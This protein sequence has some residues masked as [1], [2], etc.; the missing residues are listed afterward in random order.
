MAVNF[1]NPAFI[2]RTQKYRE[3]GLIVDFFC[4]NYGKV[5]AVAKKALSFKG[6]LSLYQPFMPLSISWQGQSELKQLISIESSGNSV[7]LKGLIFYS[8]CYLNELLLKLLP[9]AENSIELFGQYL[10]TINTLGQNP[11]RSEEE[12]VLRS[13]ESALIKH[14]GY[15]I[16]FTTT[17]YSES[18]VNIDTNYVLLPERGF[19]TEDDF[20]SESTFRNRQAGSQSLLFSGSHLVELSKFGLQREGTRKTAKII[21]RIMIDY[22]LGD[23]PLNSRKIY[24]QMLGRLQNK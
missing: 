23:K 16:G 18:I 21:N 19:I 17:D 12:I 6:Y 4:P 7:H 5:S 20:L 11:S 3:T 14:L 2:L 13:F 15:E 24:G 1:L 8:A 9:V 10:L 22:L